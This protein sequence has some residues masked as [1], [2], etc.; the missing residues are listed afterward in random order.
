[1]SRRYA[2]LNSFST[3]FEWL[4]IYTPKAISNYY[5]S[6][7]ITIRIVSDNL[8]FHVEPFP[9]NKLLKRNRLLAERQWELQTK[10]RNVGN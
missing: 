8:K 2:M 9:D 5:L 7:A 4:K 6:T 1:V 3:D 10:T